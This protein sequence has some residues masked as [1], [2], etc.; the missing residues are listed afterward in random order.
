MN[1]FVK[2]G[3]KPEL[4]LPTWLIKQVPNPFFQSLNWSIN[5][6][7][8]YSYLSIAISFNSF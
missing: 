4:F 2:L 8:L 3:I 7:F 1:I 6:I 5:E